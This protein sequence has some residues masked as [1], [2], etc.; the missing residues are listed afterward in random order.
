MALG[1]VRS[2]GP[3]TGC[4]GGFQATRMKPFML[5]L[6]NNTESGAGDDSRTTAGLE[7]GATS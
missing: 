7:S 4:P 6:H 1:L 3:Q 2:A 5:V